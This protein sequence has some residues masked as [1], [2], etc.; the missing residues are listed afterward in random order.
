MS[1]ANPKE[2]PGSFT[3]D[4]DEEIEHEASLDDGSRGTLTRQDIALAIHRRIEGMSCREAKR[5]TDLVIEEMAATLASGESLKLHDFGSFLVRIKRERAGR[6]P[7]TGEPVP[8][9]A[10]RVITFKASPNMKAAINGKTPP[11][12]LKKRA[13]GR[14]ARQPG[15]IELARVFAP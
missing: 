14:P 15:R 4:S 9:E 12:K 3:R 7:R 8:I 13:R 2:M 10:R 11:T 5:L 6:N 1:I